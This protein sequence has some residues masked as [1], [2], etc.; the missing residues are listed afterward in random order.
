MTKNVYSND[1]TFITNP[2]RSDLLREHCSRIPLVPFLSFLTVSSFTPFPFTCCLS[3]FSADAHAIPPELCLTTSCI[4]ALTV[5]ASLISAQ[6]HS[7][8]KL[9]SL[10]SSPSPHSYPLTDCSSFWCQPNRAMFDIPFAFDMITYPQHP[11]LI[12]NHCSPNFPW[13][14]LLTI[15][16]FFSTPFSLAVCST[17]N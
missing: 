15:S 16:S 1:A 10:N 12:R 4:R 7:L 17:E 5:I 2:Q 3:F 9:C 11:D 14:S 6:C 13:S 8:S